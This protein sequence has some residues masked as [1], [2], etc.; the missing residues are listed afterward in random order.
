M[1]RVA[2]LRLG[3]FKVQ[4][5]ANTAWAF[6]TASQ[7]DAQLFAALSR[8]AEQR[9]VDFN[10]FELANAA[11]AIT[12]VSQSDA[13]MFMFSALLNADCQGADFQ[14]AK[15]TEPIAGS[16]ITKEPIETILRKCLSAKV[17]ELMC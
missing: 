11:Q 8:A 5:L 1:A 12:I 17:K 10:V 16:S 13:L 9:M 6:V 3:D 7:S 15:R 14:G 4:E 2:E